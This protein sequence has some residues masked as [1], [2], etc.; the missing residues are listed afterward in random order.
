MRIGVVLLCLVVLHCRSSEPTPTQQA[1][2]QP[3]PP[4]GQRV[5]LLMHGHGAA[6]DDLRSLAARLHQLA[7]KVRFELPGAPHDYGRGASWYPPFESATPQE[8]EQLT[9]ELR[10]QARQV[11]FEYLDRLKAE[12]VPEG[13]IFVG[14]FSQGA[15]VALDV[16]LSERGAHLG[17]LI[18]LSG[19]ALDLDPSGLGHHA[20]LRA[21]V[22]HGGADQRLPQSKSLALV[23]AL[24][25]GGHTVR[26]VPFGGGHSIPPEVVQALG[27]FLA[28]P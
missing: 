13:A 7:P 28:D 1:Q 14:G 19:G 23:R 10:A 21:F 9:L 27:Q 15:T 26:W 5:V 3:V 6:R 12:G 18:S 17:G 4:G 11:V 24:Q 8:A 2:P 22:S 25:Q 16:V 20:P